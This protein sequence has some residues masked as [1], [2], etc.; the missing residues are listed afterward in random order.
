MN[1]L[2][3]C[4]FSGIVRDAFV[5]RGHYA[6]SCDILPTEREG[7]HYQGDVMDILD[8]DW[9]MM[10][11]HPPC[12]Y[13]SNA[14]IRWFNEER[15]GEK[16]VLRKKL[17]GDALDFV[18]KLATAHIDRIAIENPVGWV[19][20]HWRKPDQT[21]Q[22]YWF[23]DTESKRTCLWLKDLPLLKKTDVVE[24]KIHGYFKR[25]KK[26][27]QPIY[28]TQYCKFSEDR[29]KLRSTTSQGIADAM[30]DQWG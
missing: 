4:E 2:V 30:A 16:A 14:G 11:A 17:R 22:P 7:D 28:R 18:M 27:G 1:V 26:K 10:I 29:W 6:V 25:G 23:G 5:S 13:L 20:S 24:P 9:D 15:Y 21:I 3:A 8:G 12:T 19:N